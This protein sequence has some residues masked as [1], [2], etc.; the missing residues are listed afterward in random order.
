MVNPASRRGA[1]LLHTAEGAFRTAGV[2]YHVLTTGKPGHA[3]ES[4]RDA[5]SGWDAV[6]VLGGDG[7]VMEVVGA[8]AG[9]GIPVGVLPGGTGNLIAGSLGVPS[10][11]DRAVRALLAGECRRVDLGRFESGVYFAFAAGLGIDATMIASTGAGHKR[12]WGVLAY[13]LSAGTAALRRP[14]FNLTAV[15]DGTEVRVPAI[16]AMVANAG[17]LFGGRLLLGPGISAH[18]GMLDLC[19]LSPRTTRDVLGIA[20][21]VVRKDFRPHPCMRFLKGKRFCL[22]SEPPQAVQADGELV[23]VTPVVIEVAPLAATFLVPRR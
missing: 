21:R 10:R 22:A 12:R 15:V 17:S 1:R 4:V 8:L 11:V 9:T 3:L 13:F 6:F 19:V 20:W 14:E 2:A 16:L 18:D 23:A 5:A 7:T